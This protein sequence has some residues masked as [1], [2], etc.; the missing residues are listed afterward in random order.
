MTSDVR[1]PQYDGEQHDTDSSAAVPQ[2]SSDGANQQRPRQLPA[3]AK[4]IT[5]R[6]PN[7]YDK[8]A[9]KLE[10]SAAET[11]AFTLSASRLECI[12]C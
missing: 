8:T 6:I 10:V 5:A 3:C 7:A 12:L 9:L 2:Q 4:V 11:W 1:S